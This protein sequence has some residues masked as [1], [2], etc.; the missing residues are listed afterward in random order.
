M[1]GGGEVYPGRDTFGDK[2]E[3]V[4]TKVT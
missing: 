3:K 2:T 4:E 1:Q